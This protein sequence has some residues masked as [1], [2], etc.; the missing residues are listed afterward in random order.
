MEFSYNIQIAVDDNSRIILANSV[1][2]YPTD[3][4]QLI[5]QIEQ[6]ITTIGQLPDHTTISADNG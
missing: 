3:Y 6:T 1:T 5:L 4:Y 2:Q